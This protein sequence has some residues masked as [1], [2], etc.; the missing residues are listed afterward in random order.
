[1]HLVL[2]A[3]GGSGY[4]AAE[5][6]L[7]RGE[8]VRL[9]VRNPS[10]LG[11]LASNRSVEVVR[12][13]ALSATDVRK[14]AEGASSIFHSVNV[15]YQEWNRKAVPMLE[16]TLAAAKATGAKIVFPENVYV[17]GHAMTEFVREDHP[18]R[19]HTRKGR[20][21][22]Q[23]EQRLAK[24]YKDE[25]VPYTIV[26]MPDFYGPH[27]PNP[28][29]ASIFRNALGGRPMTWYGSLDIPFEFIYAEDVGEGLVMAG[30]DSSTAGETYHLPGSAPTTP[31]AWLNLIT[32][33]A[34]TKP[35][36]RTISSKLVA[37]AGLV[38]PLAREFREMLYL[39]KERFLLDGSKFREKF[40]R[41]PTTSYEEGVRTT[42]DWFRHNSPSS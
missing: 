28:I 17:F 27:I 3:T 7:A 14:A 8:P 21:R 10:K 31:R 15:P 4:W 36:V 16:N 2:G 6:L 22:V 13:D 38:N 24:A 42:L 12:G 30:L 32:T 20:L 35:K 37:L 33:T 25:G 9:L 19:P 29:Y 5:K 1:M 39:R 23:M 11:E 18:M 41:I 26:R 34:G 40:G